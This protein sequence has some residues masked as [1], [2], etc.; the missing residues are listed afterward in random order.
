MQVIA[1]LAYQRTFTPGTSQEPLV[2]R[3]GIERAEEAQAPDEV[4]DEG[5]D[6]TIRSVLSLP[7]GT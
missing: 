6:G 7:S 4:A 3:Q 5:I 2:S 1:E